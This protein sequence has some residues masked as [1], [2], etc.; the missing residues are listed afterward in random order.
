MTQHV[1]DR[2]RRVTG[3]LHANSV[4]AHG[5]GHGRE[6]GVLKVDP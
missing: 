1:T 2:V 3:V 5:A 4:N 6:V